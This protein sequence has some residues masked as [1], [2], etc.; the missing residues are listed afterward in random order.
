MTP[1]KPQTPPTPRP[2]A[3]M[4]L[5]TFLIMVLIPVIALGCML[6][7]R[8]RAQAAETTLQHV[9][10]ERAASSD[11]DPDH[12]IADGDM[13]LDAVR[14][15]DGRLLSIDVTKIPENAST[16]HINAPV[17]GPYLDWDDK[18]GFAWHVG[19]SV[20]PAIEAPCRP[21]LKSVCTVEQPTTYL[22]RTPGQPEACMIDGKTCDGRIVSE[23]LPE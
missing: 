6:Y 3:F 13:R 19:N 15:S 11:P 4:A 16:A 10:E 23:A 8:D 17:R 9:L 20:L 7:E 18:N 14:G 1:P 21:N 22:S 5:S 2:S 12:V